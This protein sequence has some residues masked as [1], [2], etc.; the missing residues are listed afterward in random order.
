MSQ[1]SVSDMIARIKRVVTHFN[2]SALAYDR[3]PKI[4]EDL[5]LP[6]KKL[7]QDVPTRYNSTFYLLQRLLEMKNAIVL[8]VTEHDLQTS[9]ANEWKL[10]ENVI[11]L[12]QPFEE[13]TKFLQL[14]SYSIF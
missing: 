9:T 10:V 7:V 12:L 3:L 11:R 6:K 5:N 2:H 4:Q 1:P 13:Y 8:Y 14:Q